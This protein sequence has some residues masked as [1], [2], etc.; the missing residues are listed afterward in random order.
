MRKLALVALLAL[1]VGAGSAHA[2]ADEVE[3][4][5]VSQ[6]VVEINEA[7]AILNGIIDSNDE[8]DAIAADAVGSADIGTIA[9][10]DTNATTTATLYAPAFIG[11][12]L[13]GSEGAGTN[14]LWISKG[15]TTN[16]W[17][18]VEP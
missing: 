16:D 18:Q 11:Q 12:V 9:Q 2:D 6:L 8:V 14:A 15:A 13:V 10:T 5:I 17:V 7:I 1:A 3:S 4:Y